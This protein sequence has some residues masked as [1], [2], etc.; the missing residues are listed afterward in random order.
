MQ[1]MLTGAE[2]VAWWMAISE[3][4][5]GILEVYILD[6]DVRVMR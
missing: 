3:L 1:A 6:F 2:T 4:S 5:G